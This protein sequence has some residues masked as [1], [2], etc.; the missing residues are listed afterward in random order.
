M[1]RDIRCFR[2]YLDHDAVRQVVEYGRL[3]HMAL[4]QFLG[5]GRKFGIGSHI[6]PLYFVPEPCL[7][8]FVVQLFLVLAQVCTSLAFL[9]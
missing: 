7:G 8:L 9:G 2:Y 6:I 1:D 3:Q 5:E 4:R